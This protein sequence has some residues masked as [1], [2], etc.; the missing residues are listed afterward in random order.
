MASIRLYFSPGACSRVSMIALEETGLDYTA[1]RVLLAKGEQMT[2]EFRAI[3]P[4]G[5][6]PALQIDN[7]VLTENLAILT[8]LARRHPEACLLPIADPWEEAEALSLLSWCA[9][10]LHPLVTRLRLPQRFCDLPGTADR[11]R[12]LARDEMIG[13]LSVAEE[14]LSHQPWMLG[15][16]WS[17]A[18]AYLAWAWGRCPESG[19]EAAQ[20]P[21]LCRHHDKAMARPAAQRAIQREATS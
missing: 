19:I 11:V 17:I 20:F 9:A 7:R 8:F 3:N 13:Q 10:G 16:A 18:D 4:K 1:H 14:R 6:V 15:Q 21:H 5:K 2:P 12:D